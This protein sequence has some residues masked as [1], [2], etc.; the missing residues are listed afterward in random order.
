MN[1]ARLNAASLHRAGEEMK[2]RISRDVAM[3]EAELNAAH[4]Q[5]SWEERQRLKSRL[6]VISQKCG[7]TYEAS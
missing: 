2:I 3:L 6:M 1:E 4:L 7:N 5:I